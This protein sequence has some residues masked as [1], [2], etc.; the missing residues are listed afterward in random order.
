VVGRTFEAVLIS[1]QQF[2]CSDTILWV[3]CR[4]LFDEQGNCFC[5]ERRILLCA[6]RLLAAGRPLRILPNSLIDTRLPF[7]KQRKESKRRAPQS[8]ILRTGKHN[9]SKVWAL[10]RLNACRITKC[11]EFAV[12]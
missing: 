4:L 1:R 10:V 9:P 3:L 2:G 7:G 11:Q 12:S 8:G 5:Y 6:P